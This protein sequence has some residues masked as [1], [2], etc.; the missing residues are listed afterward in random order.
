MKREM[1]VFTVF[2]ICAVL[3]FS[4]ASVYA[5]AV[6]TSQAWMDWTSL[7]IP[8]NITW[9]D[10]NS[11]SYAYAEDAT[12]SDEDFQS[13]S[14]WVD[15]YAFASIYHSAIE[16]SGEALTDPDRLYEEVYGFAAI[17]EGETITTWARSE[18]YARR[19]SYFIADLD[20]WITFSVDYELSQDLA[21]NNA[22]EW[23]KGTANAELQL[24]N[25]DTVEEDEDIAVLEN[26]VS[27][28]ASK[29]DGGIGTLTVTVYF[30]AG[31]LG[32]F[33][34]RVYNEAIAAIPEPMTV[35][36]LGLGALGLIRRKPVI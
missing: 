19:W 15:T 29:S 14:G 31:E 5:E 10:G 13:E 25:T 17:D 7:T 11:E 33:E 23:A 6:S 30:G 8:E 26:F 28:G 9:V 24:M 4:A 12:G 34:A 2:F 35:V 21:T 16:T 1:S 18:A 22:G 32:Y 20:G 27:D 3:T 36:L